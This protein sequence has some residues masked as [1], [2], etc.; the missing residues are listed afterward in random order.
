M[1]KGVTIQ[2]ES[3]QVALLI[4]TLESLMT[5]LFIRKTTEAVT[6]LDFIP[7]TKEFIKAKSCN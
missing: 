3:D 1:A 2:P 6:Q 5:L 7:F 4:T